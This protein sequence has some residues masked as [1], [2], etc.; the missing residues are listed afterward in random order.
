M[1]ISDDAT[2]PSLMIWKPE[3]KVCGASGVLSVFRKALRPCGHTAPAV[4]RSMAGEIMTQE[5]S[6]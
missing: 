6:R 2:A 3:T 4:V 1:Y 5:R